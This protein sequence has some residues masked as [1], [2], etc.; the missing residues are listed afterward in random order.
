MLASSYSYTV[1]SRETPSLAVSLN[2]I[3][4]HD[5]P[6]DASWKLRQRG[7]LCTVL[8]S[9]PSQQQCPYHVHWSSGR[10][11]KLNFRG[12]SFRSIA[13]SWHRCKDITNKSREIGLVGRGSSRG[14][15]QQV[16]RVVRRGLWRTTRHTD[17]QAAIHRSRPPADQSGKR[18]ASWTGSHRARPTC[19]GHPCISRECHENV[20][21]KTAPWNLSFTSK[22]TRP[23]FTIFYVCLLLP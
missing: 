13:S 9:S 12:S 11:L 5:R 14:C 15:P 22:T 6:S 23:N 8:T 18:V 2:C 16:V 17:K 4:V 19:Y 20:T 1:Y 3:P 10:G 7:R 21:R